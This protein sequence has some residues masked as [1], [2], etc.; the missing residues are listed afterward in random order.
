MT[1]GDSIDLRG[2]QGSVVL[3]GGTVVQHYPQARDAEQ[4]SMNPRNPDEVDSRL[5][6]QGRE[7]AEVKA[8]LT[9]VEATAKTTEADVKTILALL[10]RPSFGVTIN[11]LL[12][13]ILMAII[14]VALVLGVS[15][16]G[17]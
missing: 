17:Q 13:S 15:Y 14:V 7:L 11:Q 4:P 1:P 12:V 8:R 9:A 6:D 10:Q 16:V 3:P 5:Y 2:T